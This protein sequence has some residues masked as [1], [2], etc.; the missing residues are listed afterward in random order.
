VA[1][2]H[3]ARRPVH[4]CTEIVAASPPGPPW[5][6]QAGVFR[7]IGHPLSVSSDRYLGGMKLAV[8]VAAAF[9]LAG[10]TGCSHSPNQWTSVRYH[11]LVM[12]VPRGLPVEQTTNPFATCRA[13]GPTASVVLIDD[14]APLAA[15]PECGA[16]GLKPSTATVV[17]IGQGGTFVPPPSWTSMAVHGVQA[18]R[19]DSPKVANDPQL[20]AVEFTAS[21]VIVVI[22]ASDTVSNRIIG[23][24]RSDG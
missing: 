6:T 19:Y 16:V 13:I 11:G 22:R 15:S 10:L 1:D 17:V 24:T 21:K 18:R 2:D 9:V 20:T 3:E 7:H 4:G 8:A 5:R 14:G 12:A 23:E